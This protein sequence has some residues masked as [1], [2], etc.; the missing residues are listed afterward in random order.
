M[1]VAFIWVFVFRADVDS[2]RKPNRPE[3]TVATDTFRYYD[4]A[5]TSAPREKF[6]DSVLQSRVDHY[7]AEDLRKAPDDRVSTGAKSA[8]PARLSTGMPV[9][10]PTTGFRQF[11]AVGSLLSLSINERQNKLARQNPPAG[12]P[13]M[14]ATEVVVE[15]FETESAN[16]P[17]H[18]RARLAYLAR[19]THLAGRQDEHHPSSLLLPSS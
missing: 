14:S 11:S 18:A 17:P 1:G 7:L 2:A 5:S 13:T 10:R 12:K 4:T 3:R 8:K 15:R 19:P 16:R 6:F 9:G